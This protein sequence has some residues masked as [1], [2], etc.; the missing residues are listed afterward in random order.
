MV[1][2]LSSTEI[3]ITIVLG[4]VGL[5]IPVIDALKKEEDIT[6]DFTVRLLLSPCHLHRI[7][8]FPCNFR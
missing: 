7:C 5:A 8:N 4:V 6:T 3:I 2:D 1:V